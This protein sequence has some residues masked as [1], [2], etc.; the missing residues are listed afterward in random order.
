[1]QF[2]IKEKEL[3]VVKKKQKK[4]RLVQDFVIFHQLV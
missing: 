3:R 2:K 4:T 1:M